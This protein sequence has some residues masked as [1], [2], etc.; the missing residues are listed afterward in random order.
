L[1]FVFVFRFAT[2]SFF[3]F[4]FALSSH[5]LPSLVSLGI[6]HS[7]STQAHQTKIVIYFPSLGLFSSRSSSNSFSSLIFPC[8]FT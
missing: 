2:F 4:F 8:F 3:L 5:L 1:C 7:S 6:C